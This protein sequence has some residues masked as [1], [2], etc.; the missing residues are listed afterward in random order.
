[1]RSWAGR[2]VP[3]MGAAIGAGVVVVGVPAGGAWVHGC[4]WVWVPAGGCGGGGCVRRW[5][6]GCVRRGDMGAGVMGCAGVQEGGGEGRRTRPLGIYG[7]P[8]EICFA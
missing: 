5:V 2:S 4:A 7:P 8:H 1:M 6:R 3:A